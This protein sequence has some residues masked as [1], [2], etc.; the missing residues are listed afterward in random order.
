MTICFFTERGDAFFHNGMPYWSRHSR[1]A[2][3]NQLQRGL[4]DGVAHTGIDDV[5]CSTQAC[6]QMGENCQILRHFLKFYKK[7]GVFPAFGDY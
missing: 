3:I 2:A 6:K 4:Y 5:E 1:A 7:Q